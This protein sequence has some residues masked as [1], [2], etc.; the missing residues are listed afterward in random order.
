MASVLLFA[1][2]GPVRADEVKLTTALEVG[3]QISLSVNPGLKLTLTWGDGQ[4]ETL[5]ASGTLQNLTV[6]HTDLTISTTEGS[7]TALYL[8]GNALTNLDV[9]KAPELKFLLAADNQLAKIDLAK[10]TKLQSVDLQGNRLTSFAGS[11]LT[12][13]TDL[14]VAAMNLDLR[15]CAWLIRRDRITLWRNTTN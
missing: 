13:L 5:T 7:L 11:T 12:E 15:A 9:T 14:N 10:C 3:K 4:T 8:Q 1:A 2:A 6:K